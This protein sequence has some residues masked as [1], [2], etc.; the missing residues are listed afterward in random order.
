ME[1]KRKRERK[2]EGGLFIFCIPYPAAAAAAAAAE[3]GGGGG[4]GGNW[5]APLI[6]SIIEIILDFGLIKTFQPKEHQSSPSLACV[7][8]IVYNVMY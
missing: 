3:A 8:V 6:S 2:R 4:E 7:E 5:L 1:E